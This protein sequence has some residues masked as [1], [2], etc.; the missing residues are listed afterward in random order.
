MPPPAFLDTNVPI[1]AAG[2]PHA[3][4]EPSATILAL[5]AEH[6]TAFFTNAEVLQELLHRYRALGIWSAG[7]TVFRAFAMLMDG[8]VEAVGAADLALAADLADAHAGLAARDLLHLAVMRRI[9]ATRVVSADRGFD[10]IDGI[11][12][13][14]P[15]DVDGWSEMLR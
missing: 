1:S 10:G 9:G 5:V 2:R 4:K 14:D 11:E 15:A 8:R 7:R 13:L 6:P 12:R 3:L